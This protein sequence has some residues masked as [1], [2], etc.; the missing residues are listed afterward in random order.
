M[1]PW[2]GHHFSH[3]H[4]DGLQR[5]W[6][7][8]PETIP[9][10]HAYGTL[11]SHFFS[12]PALSQGRWHLLTIQVEAKANPKV[13][14]L[15][16]LPR[17]DS[18]VYPRLMTQMLV[19]RP[20]FQR[21]VEEAIAGDR[22]I[23]VV[24]RGNI[25]SRDFDVSDLSSIGT[26]AMV[27][28]MLKL[29]DGAATVWLQGETRI[30]LLEVTQTEPWYR[31]RA[32]ILEEPEADSLQIQA[33][34]RS[35]LALFEKCVQLSPNLTW[36]VYV[37]AM[38]ATTPGWLADMV[39]S[40][41]NLE[42]ETRQKLMEVLDPEERL[43]AVNHELARE[44]EL[45]ELQNQIDSQV[46]ETLDKSQREYVLREQLRAIQKELSEVD[47]QSQDIENLKKKIEASGMPEDAAK[48]AN[49]ELLR[50]EHIP[51]ASPENP[52]IRG[53]LEWLSELPWTT[54]TED[55]L[56]IAQ[57][58]RLLDEHHYGLKK[59]KERILE[60]LAVR[61]LSQ[62]K[63]RSPILCFVGA[64]GVGKTSLGRS[65]AE[66][67]GRKF[68]RV[69]LGGIRDEA[70]IRGHRRTYVGA[71]PGRVI[72]T[73]R[74]AGTINPV[75]VLDEIDK[76]GADYRGDPSSA[77]LEV[78]DP[79]QNHSFSDHY[80]EVP[81]NLS[82]VLFIT[83]ANLL[84]PI[85]PALHDRMEV[86]ELPGYTEEEKLEI[87]RRFLVPKQL[88][89]HGLKPEQ[90]RFSSGALRRIVREY[91]REAGVRSMEREIG[92][93][94]RK[95]ARRVA[96]GKEAPATVLPQSLPKHLGA[97]RFAW[98]TAEE[99]D[100]IGVAT[101]VAYTPAGGDV[102]SV[103]VALLKG[104]GNLL[105]TGQL[106]DVMKESAQAAVSY[107]R[108]KSE[109]WGLKDGL[110]GRQDIHIHLPAGATPKDGP[111][112]GA[113]LTTALASALTR[114]PVRKEVA[115]TGEITLRGKVLPVG[116]VK[117]KVLAAH[118]AGIKVFVL[119][120]ENRK[121]AA[122]IPLKVRRDIQFVYVKEMDSV[123]QV[124]LRQPGS[125]KTKGEAA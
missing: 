82:Q 44:V 24:G 71:L 101:G 10:L 25:G 115:M 123:L 51:P 45:L 4:Q 120:E 16:L 43:N 57:A 69:S 55:N 27:G 40:S 63:L 31:A 98:G 59:V 7:P 73:M 119:P 83:T 28:R 11:D 12:L 84:D 89:E 109:A 17:R 65:I 9:F 114:Q 19:V 112:A 72:Q 35:V 81:Y 94:C 48:K 90:L 113:A 121:D 20:A 92:S 6:P 67:M 77:L 88:E 106:G 95:V 58:A 60:Y 22:R 64:P 39:C 56:D 1:A 104:K 102:L 15:P 125:L 78:L 66:A 117:E 124:A 8:L 75:L 87:A 42:L 36:D 100:E 107:C 85:L 74:R 52:V 110:F 122:D 97:P 68:I 29:P 93:I 70:E 53:Y 80:L 38:N 86:I 76:V 30:R 108:S 62:G 118:R 103:E 96:E 21:A 3:H 37:A 18:L 14:E 41:L 99:Q 91:T 49:E 50:L 47:P 79:E 61:K 13:V 5:I 2:S 111:S 32:E 26:L 54:R 105:L 23:L 116:G 34:M 33:T 46:R